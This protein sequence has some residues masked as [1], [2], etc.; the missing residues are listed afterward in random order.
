MLRRIF[1]SEKCLGG[2][3][4][5]YRGDKIMTL[6]INSYIRAHNGA[7][8]L[9]TEKRDNSA[10]LFFHLSGAVFDTPVQGI[11]KNLNAGR[12]AY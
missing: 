6:S 12:M 8:T 5:G 10:S 7:A 4:E 9:V 3:C 2:L 1:A 11:G